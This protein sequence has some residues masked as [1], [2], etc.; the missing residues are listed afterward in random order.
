V[1]PWH[2]HRGSPSV[3][4]TLLFEEDLNANTGKGIR[5]RE[6][7]EGIMW[8]QEQNIQRPPWQ[9]EAWPTRRKS[10]K[11]SSDL[12]LSRSMTFLCPNHR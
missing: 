4:A 12:G 8:N 7:Y 5:Q 10:E 11:D 6:P 3:P 1:D 9:E 2:L